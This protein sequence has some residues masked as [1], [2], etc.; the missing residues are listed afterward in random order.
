VGR[1]TR[2]RAL[3]L[4]ANPLEALPASLARLPGLEKLDLRWTPF[5]PDLPP[6]AQAARDRGAIVLN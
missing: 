5:F 4:R 6:A 2:L 1:L 3:D